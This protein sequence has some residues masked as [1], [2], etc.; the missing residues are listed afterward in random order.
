[1]TRTEAAAVLKDLAEVASRRG[2]KGPTLAAFIAS[3]ELQRPYYDPHS[4]DMLLTVLGSYSDQLPPDV[5]EAAHRV[6][7]AR[8]P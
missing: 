1:M 8:Q 6:R 4:V 2:A 3:E 5:C 7:A